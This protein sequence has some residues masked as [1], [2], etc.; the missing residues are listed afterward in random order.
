LTLPG[1]RGFC[2]EGVTVSDPSLVGPARG[3]LRVTKALEALLFACLLWLL[4]AAAG[5][6]G[7]SLVVFAGGALGL[8]ALLGARVALSRRLRA[9]LGSAP[10]ALHPSG[11]WVTLWPGR[12]TLGWRTDLGGPAAAEGPLLKPAL[13][14]LLLAGVQLVPGIAGGRVSVAPVAT[15]WGVALLGS[16]VI[17]HAAA[18]TLGHR[19]GQ[20]VRRDRTLTALG[21]AVALVSLAQYASGSTRIWGL[22]EP[23]HPAG[24][25][26][27]PFWYRNH[28]ATFVVLLFPLALGELTRRVARWSR[29]L[30]RTRGRRLLTRLGGEEGIAVVEWSIPPVVLLASLVATTS[31][32]ALLALVGGLLLSALVCR[33]SAKRVLFVLASTLACV[34][35][36][37]A[38]AGPDRLVVRFARA[39]ED[40]RDRVAGWTAALALCTERPVLGWGLGAYP[41]AVALHAPLQAR[42]GSVHKHLL[43]A[44]HDDYL[45]LGAEMGLPA[46]G[47]ALWGAA[48]ALGKARRDPWAFA[49]LAGLLLHAAIDFPL[50]VPALGALAVVIAAP[51]QGPDRFVAAPSASV[52]RVVD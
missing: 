28:F 44:P 23:A 11:R 17:L 6:P 30:L 38:L 1:L 48:A 9:R 52:G 19:R 14:V 12:Q 4:V 13:L 41:A 21:L 25:P 2:A 8:L 10:L 42:L 31:R 39:H 20:S 37:L 5:V 26:F 51:A 29:V 27:G 47:V 34:G 18:A 49:S 3:L 24:V 7:W 22:I 35:L 40:V 46:L 36:A 50:G 45:Q 16:L 43:L 33:P 32:G 15:M